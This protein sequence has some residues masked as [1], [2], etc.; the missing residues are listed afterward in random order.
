MSSDRKDAI[1]QAVERLVLDGGPD[2]VT[3]RA[4]AKEAGVSV[5]LVQ[6][7]GSTK[8]ELLEGALARLSEKSLDQWRSHLPDD[9]TDAQGVLRGFLRTAIPDDDESRRFHRFGVT[10]EM[11]AVT[12]PS[13]T[14]RFYTAH[15]ADVSNALAVALG[16]RPD[17][18]VPQI[19]TE[20]LAFSHG[21]GTLVMTGRL[22]PDR[23]HELAEDF[24]SRIVPVE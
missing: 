19:V 5:R 16:L 13:G 9:A 10:L 7:Y 22:D 14:G 6:Y 4:V 21:L 23:A 3:M 2:A 15:L 24:L 12:D 17:N 18:S 8:T 11:L 20:I 1:L